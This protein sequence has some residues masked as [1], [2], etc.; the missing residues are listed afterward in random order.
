[1]HCLYGLQELGMKFGL[2]G[3]TSLSKGFQII[4]RF[5]EDIDIRVEPPANRNVKTG[6]NQTKPAQ[7]QSRAAFYDG[8]R[9]GY[10]ATRKV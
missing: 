1:M 6:R 3:G 9:R 5:S 7:V 10:V 8:G 4:N 2:K